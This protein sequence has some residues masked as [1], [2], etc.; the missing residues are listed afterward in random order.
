MANIV[1]VTI[2]GV[3]VIFGIRQSVQHF[4]GESGCCGGGGEVK[5]KRKKL[6]N[7]IETKVVIVEGMTC[8]HCRTRVENRLNEMDG[9]SANVN[10]KRKEAVIRAE[11]EISDEEII[12]A[13]E[14]AGYSVSSIHRQICNST[15]QN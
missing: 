3:V 8:D 6:K 12:A 13:V 1:I 11:R 15:A 9:I 7:V 4:K 2:L 5:V 14:R 10:L